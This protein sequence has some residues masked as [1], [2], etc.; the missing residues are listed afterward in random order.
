MIVGSGQTGCQIA[1]K[2]L[3]RGSVVIGDQ[4]VVIIAASVVV[5]VPL[6]LDRAMDD[7]AIYS[8]VAAT[9][10]YPATDGNSLSVA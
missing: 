8:R 7:I 9:R 2:L 3:V 5:P 6:P 10:A 1:E 4:D